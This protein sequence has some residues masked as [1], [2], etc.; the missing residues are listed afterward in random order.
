MLHIPGMLRK[1]HTTAVLG[2]VVSWTTKS[3]KNSALFRKCVHGLQSLRGRR[4]PALSLTY[5]TSSLE[6]HN[7]G[8]LHRIS[9]SQVRQPDLSC[10]KNNNTRC[11]PSTA[12]VFSDV[13]VK[14][15]AS[16]STPSPTSSPPPPYQTWFG[17]V[18]PAWEW[19]SGLD[20]CDKG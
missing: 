13:W 11:N 12:Y 18:G 7:T 5:L 8:R 2:A 6:S 15:T 19:Q 14:Q 3:D 17:G 4:K 16:N 1:W 20:L 9:T 10:S